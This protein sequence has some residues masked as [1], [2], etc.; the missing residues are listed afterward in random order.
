MSSKNS[1]S[2]NLQDVYYF[3]DANRMDTLDKGYFTDR[4]TRVVALRDSLMTLPTPDFDL[5][6]RTLEKLVSKG[7]KSTLA[8]QSSPEKSANDVLSL[9]QSGNADMKSNLE[10]AKI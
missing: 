5:A 10:V 2:I 9:L 7:K 4:T 6:V 8:K 1:N 3:F